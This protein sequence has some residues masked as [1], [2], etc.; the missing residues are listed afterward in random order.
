MT[1]TTVPIVTDDNLDALLNGAVPQRVG[2]VEIYAPRPAAEATY[3]SAAGILRAP[4][5]FGGV[6]EFTP[7]Q[8]VMT[9]EQMVLLS[10]LGVEAN[11]DPRVVA[12]F[13]IEC[14]HRELDPWQREAY[15]MLYA[16][17]YI[18]H[19]GIDGF[20]TRGEST[21]EYRGRKAPLFCDED[22]RWRETWPYR[23]KAPFAS[24][25]G[26]SRAGFDEVQWNIAHYDEFG[27]V[28]ERL[29]NDKA[30]KKIPTG[31]L[32]PTSPNWA[33]AGKGGK[34]CVMLGKV[35][36]AG[37]WRVAF[38]R[39]FGGFY[40]PE[41]FDRVR[42]QQAQEDTGAAK[43]REA[44]AAAQAQSAEQPR[45]TIT[46]QATVGAPVTTEPVKQGPVVEG[47]TDDEA[48]VLLLAEL[49]EQAEVLGKTT[50][51][52]CARWSESR[53]G[54]AITTA[55]AAELLDHVHR[56]RSYVVAALREQNRDA[57]ADRYQEAP[58]AGPCEE[59]FGRGPAVVEPPVEV[60][61]EPTGV[62]Q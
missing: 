18:R 16:G 11:W 26:I 60:A 36:E 62:G 50:G 33:P 17:K 10:P 51:A 55:T 4:T 45:E 38:P 56:I 37:A 53:N 8:K 14:H 3:D 31:R 12:T 52:L 20:R 48:R 28:E 54:R 24:K 39:R 29:W 25:V 27:L 30:K 57:E 19:I 22:E 49:D 42:A 23:D 44:Y 5:P 41:E 43:R 32:A 2:E 7:D 9:K 21:G 13:L 46:V 15:L 1:T 35:A 58:Q 40:A 61:V 6:L 47:Y 59:L 34:P